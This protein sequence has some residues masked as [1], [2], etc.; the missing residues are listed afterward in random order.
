MKPT[1]SL[2]AAPAADALSAPASI[3][4]VASTIFLIGLSNTDGV[5]SLNRR[6]A[7]AACASERQSVG[8]DGSPGPVD[9]PQFPV[10]ARNEDGTRPL[11]IPRLRTAHPASCE[12]R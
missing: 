10:T 11:L 8:K 4:A 6:A 5:Y 1:F 3:T 12:L 7:P 9:A 2:S